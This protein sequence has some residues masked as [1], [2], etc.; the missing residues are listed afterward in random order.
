VPAV[1]V[2]R[3]IDG[4]RF[5]ATLP[6]GAILALDSDPP[7]DD[8]EERGGAA[9][10]GGAAGPGSASKPS[11]LLLAALAGCTGMDV[12]SIC[13]KK[14]MTWTSYE[15]EVRGEQH[16]VHPRTWAVIEVEHRFAGERIDDT[17][18]ARAIWLSAS[19]YCLVSAQLSAGNTTIHHRYAISDSEGGRQAEVLETGPHGA[20]L[21]PMG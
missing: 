15:I 5:E 10:G 12:I 6:T 14:R 3:W 1:T 13:R 19:R 17:A 2:A 8:A 20:G 21:E 11:Q 18:V 16:T 7:A 4:L 9:H